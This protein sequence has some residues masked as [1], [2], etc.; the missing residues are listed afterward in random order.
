MPTILFVLTMKVTLCAVGYF[1]YG[2]VTLFT[3]CSF[4]LHCG[5]IHL[6]HQQPPYVQDRASSRTVLNS[7]KNRGDAVTLPFTVH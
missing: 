7:C 6:M 1:V 5:I 2:L 3:H 4:I